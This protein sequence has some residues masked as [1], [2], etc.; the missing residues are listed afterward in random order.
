MKLVAIDPRGDR[1]DP[2]GRDARRDDDRSDP[3]AAGDDAIGEPV[4]EG[5]APADRDR[6]VPA[7]HD[8]APERFRRD[9]GE[10]AVDRAMGVDEADVAVPDEP[11]QTED[12]ADVGRASHSQ[13]LDR[14]R[15]C[16]RLGEEGAIGL[17]GDQR[18]PAVAE[19]PAH[20]GERTDLLTAVAAG[21]LGVQDGRHE[22]RLLPRVLE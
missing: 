10:P 3:F 21:R 18:S 14:D 11:A 8:G 1:H 13:G 20:L 9:A 4:D 7:A 2:L 6:D 12:P 19:E 15:R 16:P 5:A 22:G 17:T